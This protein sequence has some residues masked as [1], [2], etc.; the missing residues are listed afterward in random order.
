MKGVIK[1][2]TALLII[3]VLV[4][5]W[6]VIYLQAKIAELDEEQEK[7]KTPRD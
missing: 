5:S 1:V 2:L 3:T 6:R 7:E 4:L